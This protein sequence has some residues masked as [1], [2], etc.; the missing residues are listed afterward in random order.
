MVAERAARHSQ[1]T[2]CSQIPD[3]TPELEG[4]KSIS[5]IVAQKFNIVYN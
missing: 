5:A 2:R 3:T 1:V 4:R